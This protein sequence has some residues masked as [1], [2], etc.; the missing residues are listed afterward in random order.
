MDY[1]QVL[2]VLLYVYT[3]TL[4][5]LVLSVCNVIIDPDR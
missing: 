4:H 1:F 5:E 3:Y 2:R